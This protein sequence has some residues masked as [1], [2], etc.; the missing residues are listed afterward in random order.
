MKFINWRNLIAVAVFVFVFIFLCNVGNCQLTTVSATITD[1]DSTTWFNARWQVTFVPN[2]NYPNINQY[3]INGVLLTSPTYSSYLNQN[4]VTNGSGVFSTTLLDNTQIAPTGSSWK[5][6]IQ[7]YASVQASTMPNVTVSGASQSLTTFISSNVIAPRFPAIGVAF[8]YI[9]GEVSAIPNPGGSYYNVTGLVE[10]QW[11]GS[12]WTNLSGGGVN[13]VTGLAPI[14]VSP[15]TGATIVS[16]PDCNLT[17]N[18]ALFTTLSSGINATATVIPLTSVANLNQTGEI[19]IGSEWISYTGISGSSLTGATRGIHATSPASYTGGTNVYSIIFD[20]TALASAPANYVITNG[21]EA[22]LVVFNSASAAITN[23]VASVQ[24]TAD[25]YFDTSGAIIQGNG[26]SKNILQSE[27]GIGPGGGLALITNSGYLFDSTRQNN[28]TVTQGFSGGITPIINVI[29]PGTIG[30]PTIVNFAGTGAT[31]WSWRCTGTDLD[32][33]TFPGTDATITNGPAT[34]TGGGFFD[35]TCPFSS[36]AVT[37]TV[38]R[39]AGPN[40]TGLLNTA[41]MPALGVDT[42]VALT[43]SPPSSNSSVPK[44]CVGTAEAMCIQE[45]SVAPSGSCINGWLYVNSSNTP[46]TFYYC[47]ANAWTGAF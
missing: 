35:I 7:P 46:D 37:E 44:L 42:N 40:T 38:W 17:P 6:I 2:P 18:G 45:G 47:K 9:D 27:T 32:G 34:I 43:G 28:S 16:C 36:G 31:T 21:N 19:A 39:T 20:F 13:S 41:G 10:R 25:T 1:S 4:G 30:P 15:T 24:I 22:P 3:N 33:N 12:I 5:F 29:Q 14:V 26:A 8:G 11:N 23:P